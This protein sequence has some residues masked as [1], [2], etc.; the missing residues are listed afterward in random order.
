MT[1]AARA[2]R[3]EGRHRVEARRRFPWSE[4]ALQAAATLPGTGTCAGSFCSD[5]GS[6]SKQE[7]RRRDYNAAHRVAGMTRT[8]KSA[9]ESRLGRSAPPESVGMVAMQRHSRI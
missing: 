3:G 5:S 9:R 7:R 6:R 8:L 2:G 1:R 4:D